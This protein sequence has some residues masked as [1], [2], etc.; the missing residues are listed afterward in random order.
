MHLLL[1]TDNVNCVVLFRDI[2]ILSC[3]LT[4]TF[5][6]NALSEDKLKTQIKF[7]RMHV[8]AAH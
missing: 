3:G 1:R 2:Y 8:S 7:I 4:Q 5:I 6:D